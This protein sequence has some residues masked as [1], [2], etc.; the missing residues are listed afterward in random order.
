MFSALF[1]YSSSPLLYTFRMI[2]F[3]IFCL[4]VYL[5]TELCITVSFIFSLSLFIALLPISCSMT[6]SRSHSPSFLSFVPSLFRTHPLS[7][8]HSFLSLT[9]LFLSRSI[10]LSISPSHPTP[11]PLSPRAISSRSKDD[12]RFSSKEA[13]SGKKKENKNEKNERRR[14]N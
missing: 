1:L 13:K 5:S 11:H 6:V 12:R 3:Y 14:I 8:T 7:S 2:C 10:Y 4:F 9:P